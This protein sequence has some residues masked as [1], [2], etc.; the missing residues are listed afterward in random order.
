MAS[1]PSSRE[2]TAEHILALR[3]RIQRWSARDFKRSSV[4]FGLTHT[5]FAILALVHG[6][7]GLNLSSL[8]EHLDLSAPTVVRAVDAL[9]RKDLVTRTRGSQ[10][11]REVTVLATA[12]GVDAY[13]QMRGVRKQR[14]LA[15]LSGLGD[16]DLKALLRGYEA[17]A[18]ALDAGD[19]ESRAAV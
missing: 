6:A 2:R 9:E 12:S 11:H 15:A 18:N 13:E 5:Q 19:T 16:D 1:S 14:L 7:E 3:E 17:F 10:D 4:P 8:A